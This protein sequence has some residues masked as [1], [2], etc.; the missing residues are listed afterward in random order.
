MRERIA[1]AIWSLLIVYAVLIIIVGWFVGVDHIKVGGGLFGAMARPV[2]LVFVLFPVIYWLGIK[3]SCYAQ[4]DIE[5]M[6][7]AIAIPM[8]MQKARKTQRAF[9]AFCIL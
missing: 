1:V 8:L 5:W 3:I 7:P 4:E 2:I 9:R 6:K